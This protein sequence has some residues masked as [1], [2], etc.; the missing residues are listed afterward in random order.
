MTDFSRITSMLHTFE[1]RFLSALLL[2][3]IVLSSA[4]IIIRTMIG[5][6]V[7]WI[8]PVLKILVLWIAMLGAVLAS[9]DKE[10]V[11]IDVLSHYISNKYQYLIQSICTLFV[12][13]VSFIISYYSFQFVYSTYEYKDIAFNNTPL[14]IWQSII[15]IAF[16]FIAIRF[17]RHTFHNLYCS[18]HLT[19][20]QNGA[21]L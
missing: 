10:H 11:C 2:L 19:S 1:N 13:I 6:S 4:E 8:S 16:L 3:M 21:K 9:R 18:K 14:W 7:L 5:G 15:P 17:T 20:Q 12:A